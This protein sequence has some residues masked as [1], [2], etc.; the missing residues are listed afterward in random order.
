MN[1]RDQFLRGEYGQIVQEFERLNVDGTKLKKRELPWVAA[2]LALMGRVSDAF[3]LGERSDPVARFYVITAL[4]RSSD[5][6][7]ARREIGEFLKASSD[8]DPVWRFYVFQCLGFHAFFEG[9]FKKS[10]YWSQRAWSLAIKEMGLHERVLSAD[11]RGH[12]L[13]QM[14]DVEAGLES[15][16][17][18]LEVAKRFGN[19]SH[20]RALRAAIAIAEVQNGYRRD[21]SLREL[22]EDSLQSDS[23]TAANVLIELVRQANL[24]GHYREAIKIVS[25]T[26]PLIKRV[27]HKRQAASLAVRE[28]YSHFRL[29][30][31]KRAISILDS[32]EVKLDSRDRAVLVEVKG[33]K[34]QILRAQAGASAKESEG[35]RRPI[36][37]QIAKLQSEVSLLAHEVR[38]HRSLSFLRRFS[39]DVIESPAATPIDRWIQGS[40]DYHIRK[41][42]FDRGYLDFFNSLFE[43]DQPDALLLAVVAGKVLVRTRSELSAIE[44]GFSSNLRRGLLILASDRRTKEEILR[45]VW[46]YGYDPTR[47][48]NLIY[49]F[50]RRLRVALGPLGSLLTFSA[51]DGTYGFSRPVSVKVLDY[52]DESVVVDDL[53]IT[54]SFEKELLKWNPRQL[55]ILAKLRS[56]RRD[57]Q[58]LT[59]QIVKPKD[60]IEAYQVSRI[61]AGR[62]LAELT[63]GGI[64][65]RVGRGRGTGYILKS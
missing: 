7:R 24:R 37:K 25:E 16:E 64:L 53:P 22:L 46:G 40:T 55:E 56:S 4:I 39:G 50:I 28:A 26:R 61:T 10:L 17:S 52:E 5:Y 8:R 30:D 13:I 58:P 19:Q 11:L 47:H 54:P 48:D 31:S 23:Y 44:D 2:S 60:L 32:A 36:E 20:V 63:D 51:D 27:R 62:D 35:R 41:E 9:R 15:L 65:I 12:C 34:L 42:L 43:S 33:L 14:G 29:G 1:L 45:L 57:G 3:E 49:T 21:G 6:Q 18:A 59:S 38:N